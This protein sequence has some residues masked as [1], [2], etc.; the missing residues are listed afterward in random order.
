MRY[1]LFLACLVAMLALFVGIDSAYAQTPAVN[2]TSTTDNGTY[3]EGTIDVRLLL[4]ERPS[5][6]EFSIV[7][8]THH[9]GVLSQAYSVTTTQID[10]KHYALVAAY[11]D[12]GVQI[13]DITNLVRP[14]SVAN[15]T[16]NTEFDVLG[17]ARSVTTTQINGK[18][19]ALVAAYGD[20][21]VQII[22]ISTP[23]DPLSVA[24][25][26]DNTEFDVLGGAQSITTTQIN[27]KHYA[28]VAAYGDSG[29]Q[30]IDISTP[31][32]PLSV[33]NITDNTEFDVLGGA[34]SVTTT[35]INGKHYALVA[36]YG[37]SGVQIIDISTPADPLSVAN[38]TDNTEF[39][40]LD[41]AA[42]VTTTQI[43][44]KHYALVA[45]DFD[46]GVQIIDISTPADPLSVA[47][48]TDNTE[49]DV[50]SGAHSVTTTQINGKHYALVASYYNDQGVQI[51]DISTPAD[52]LSV[53]NI[54]DNTDFDNTEFDVLGGARSV[55]TTQ[56]NGKHYALVA[57]YDDSGVQ[58][59]DITDP[60]KP[61][62]PLWP[63]IA[64]D[65]DPPA[66]AFYTE[67]SGN[68]LVFEYDVGK[69]DYSPRL[70]YTGTDAFHLS[71]Y[72]LTYANGTSFPTT[73]PQPGSIGSLSYNKA[74]QIGLTPPNN[75]D[76]VIRNT[77]PVTVS[78]GATFI[79]TVTCT[80]DVDESP[81]LTH[82]P[83]DTGTSGPQTV[84]Y[85]CTDSS[86]NTVTATQSVTVT[87]DSTRPTIVIPGDNPLTII[88]GDDTYSDPAATCDDDVDGSLTPAVSG[89]VDPNT[90]GTYPVTYTCTDLSDNAATATL[91]VVVNVDVA[92]YAVSIE[93]GEPDTII[94]TMSEAV[95]NVSDAGFTI[96][97][98]VSN[99]SISISS[100]ASLDDVVTVTLSGGM[101]DSDS[102]RL[103]YNGTAG[104]VTDLRGKPLA[105]FDESVQNTLD[106]TAPTVR[107][108]TIDN[109]GTVFVRLSESVQQGSAVAND[110]TTNNS[111]ITV[112]TISVSG[113]TITLEL[114]GEIPDDAALT[115]G[116][117]GDAGKIADLEGNHLE[118]FDDEP[119]NK[120]SRKRSSSGSTPAVDLA[121][122][123]SLGYM[124]YNGTKAPHDPY[125][126]IT[127]LNAGG[128]SGFAL[129]I[130]DMH[131]LLG[132]ILNTLEPQ[133]L[134]T[135]VDNTIS[136]A[137]YDRADI[138]HFTLYMN[139]HGQ[140]TDYQ[141]SDTYITYDMGSIRIVDPHDLIS[142]ATVSIKTSGADSLRHI[143]V[144]A[145]TFE[146]EME[147][148][149]LV[150]RTWNTDASSTIV[151]I[152]NA[153]AVS[154]APPDTQPALSEDPVQE[155][156]ASEDPVPDSAMNEPEESEPAGATPDPNA[157]KMMIRTW[158][159]FEP[160]SV[161]DAQLLEALG[162]EHDGSIPSWVMTELGVLFSQD[163]ITLEE[164]TT[165]I[166]YVLANV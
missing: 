23:A 10:G 45:A 56:I 47:N 112:S 100:V 7:D 97:G 35:Q 156:P 139:L 90:P 69:Y 143:V 149:N 96:S 42:S 26:T 46:D 158:S 153:F 83:V 107:S 37:D 94:V 146:G 16:D 67:T 147:Q 159:G 8:D 41:H 22:D 24:N 110:F 133:T 130:N 109:S 51:I 60:A 20:S 145:I 27:G 150:A 166:S 3:T 118:S 148:T 55:T 50:L 12:S 114:S 17:G 103:A 78:L 34:Y 85:T 131:Y 31:A 70:A 115:L 95:Q 157:V 123:Q 136:F 163:Q 57:A 106:T 14:V 91:R 125:T 154:A 117:A 79:T 89:T 122:L 126:P 116:Y 65:T 11:D 155:D 104:S 124:D 101:L 29:V 127:P 63:F 54:T 25:I 61:F 77:G 4:S 82:T 128:S 86:D 6:E 161:T 49:F 98:I 59:I 120:Q 142:D 66:R 73:L 76:P 52:P 81:T 5:F 62:N 99:P 13:I 88:E 152:L 93:T 75:V 39:D 33:A 80:D 160:G 165:A 30:I 40:E 135:G 141:D 74:I 102:P 134:L 151:R 162:L 9:F 1:T 58:I 92:P 138:A 144:F 132:G 71:S 15:I 18:H 44:G 137:V 43:N 48:I 28:L 119:I 121:S 21:G 87:P 84:T 36:A 111:S 68:D 38:I 113:S 108:V 53:A 72:T 164:F 32:D 2:V 64:L 19:Y 105:S 140:D 129:A